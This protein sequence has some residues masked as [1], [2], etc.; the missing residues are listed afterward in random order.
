M[1]N[2]CRMIFRAIHEGK[3][4]HIE[5]RNKNEN[6]TSYW[7]GIKDMNVQART[8]SADGLHLMKYSVT[9]LNIYI[10]SIINAEIVEGTYQERNEIL[11]ND[12]KDNPERYRS[13]FGNT[14]N[15]KILNYLAE[16]NR[17][18]AT[19]YYD[20]YTLIGKID[21]QIIN[22]GTIRDLYK[23]SDEQFKSIV[24]TF[25]NA[26]TDRNQMSTLAATELGLNVISVHMTGREELYLLAYREL[27]LDVKA[28]CFRPSK[29]ITICHDFNVDEERVT[30]G[31]FLD[32]DQMY[33]I[34]DIEDHLE[35]IKD[36]I[37]ENYAQLRGVDD[38]PYI[39]KVG[40]K[41]AIDLNNE[42][43]AIADSIESEEAAI[44]VKAFFGELLKNE[45]NTKSYSYALLNKSV[46]L[47]QLL[48]I[49]NAMCGFVSY[50]QG[51]PGTGKTTTIIDTITTAFFSN[52]TVLFSSY[53]NHPVDS[54]FD[55]LQKF[56][57]KY[58]IIPFPVVRI[59]NKEKVCE[60]LIY[61]RQLYER[62]SKIKV[63][64]DNLTRNKNTEASKRKALKELLDRYQKNKDIK[65]RIET[66]EKMENK[67]AE[68][69]SIYA[70]MHGRQ[71]AMMQKELSENLEP[72]T[73]EAL[74]LIPQDEYLLSYMYFA[75]AQCI[76]RLDDNENKELHDIIMS[77]E[78]IE[79]RSKKFNKYLKNDDNVA[80]F[81]KIFPIVITTCI[82]AG[83]IGE[84][85]EHFDM[86]IIDEASQC[87]T[88]V[89]LV[90]VIRGRSLMLVGDP[91]Q[92]NPVI[93]LD[94][95][96]NNILLKRYNVTKEYNYI[97]NSIYKTFLSLDS[98]SDEVLLSHHYRCNK[99]IIKF[100]NHKY[101]NDKLKIESKNSSKE[102]LRLIEL[103]NT[104]TT[105]RNASEE[106]AE[107]VL[108]LA[109]KAGDKK[110]GII[111]P[112]AN[113]KRCIQQKLDES[114]LTNV[115]CG[116]VHSFQGDEKD[117]IIFSPGITGGTGEKTY[118]WLKNNKELINVAIS[119]AKD[120][121]IIVSDVDNIKRLHNI[122]K[123]SPDDFYELVNYVQ[124]VGHS[125]V[126][127]RGNNS[128]ALGIKPFSTE[129]EAAFFKN[130]NLA[131]E[132]IMDTTGRYRVQKEVPLKQVFC[133]NIPPVDLFYTGQFDFVVFEKNFAGQE[134]PVLAIELDGKEHTDDAAVRE[135]DRK[136]NYICA[137]HHFQLIRV[138]NTY[139]RRYYSIKDIL[140]NYFKKLNSR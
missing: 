42:Y 127:M 110:I 108:Q 27:Q 124:S 29:N 132:N 49:R 74:S 105:V 24:N 38:M 50:V 77:E 48:A 8:L 13:V 84:P 14:Y 120:Q 91:Q 89:S 86:T 90:S 118:E 62:A 23:L 11:I 114:G 52:R 9:S 98:L 26:K 88:A 87:N 134:Q 75:S 128:R 3:W 133:E 59:G 41:P 54:V 137:E 22:T 129:T 20:K 117:T 113:Q 93:L 17:L 94:E 81:L 25:S 76:Q 78:S 123:D 95:H 6:I 106:E 10:D 116:T 140:M 115:T 136:K 36:A 12:I 101:Y 100:N 47:D 135:R 126:S 5:Y 79:G 72:S 139:A 80:N 30:I 19:P 102:P 109:M 70:D 83:R 57:C 15:L 111:T 53:N 96:T 63:L 32:E 112:F 119:R 44:P 68:R 56:E 16:C 104:V 43:K 45:R 121:L 60:A 138:D 46:N 2:I 71:K 103:K 69:F 39:V 66:L 18:D 21:D 55:N 122:N 7:I 92:L 99:E 107:K 33:L 4:L 131:L 31:Q 125:E 40:R 37:T 64:K 130:L 82:S 73:E 67:L 97:K 1:N 35:E 58:G 51:P 85:M 65:D 28:K 34:E 61:M